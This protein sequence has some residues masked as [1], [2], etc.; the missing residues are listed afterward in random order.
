M[1]EEGDEANYEPGEGA[2]KVHRFVHHKGHNA[3]GENIVLHP[4]VPGCPQQLN[5]IEL[6]VCV[7]L[8]ELV[9]VAPES[10]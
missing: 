9:I 1:V 4:R 10:V 2:A 3:S 8:A 7:V 6:L 5:D